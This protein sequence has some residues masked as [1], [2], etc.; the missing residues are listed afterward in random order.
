MPFPRMMRLLQRM[1]CPK[2]DDVAQEVRRE[3][4]KLDLGSRLKPGESVAVTVG[5]RGI[6][7]LPLIIRTMVEMLT[8]QGARP[9]LV[10]AMGSHGGATAEGQ[11]GT[12]AELGIT[13]EFCGAPVKSSME[14]VQ[15]T[16]TERGLPV[17]LDRHAH[18][19]DHVVVVNRVKPH[20]VLSGE[21]ESGLQ[22]MLL[23]GL[24]KQQGADVYHRA[25]HAQSFDAI[26]RSA[27]Q[28]VIEKG[29]ILMGLAIV[30]NPIKQTALIE[31]VKPNEFWEREKKLLIQA[32]EWIP[33]LPF[34]EA[35]LLI[36]DEFGKNISGSGMDTN[37][38]GRK[39]SSHL[40]P[41][42]VSPRITAIYVRDL[43]EQ[44]HGNATGIGRVEFTH[45]RLVDKIDWPSTYMNCLTANAPHAARLPMHFD[46]DRRVL[47]AAMGS[48]LGSDDPTRARV[49]HIKNTMELTEVLVSEA[50]LA[51]VKTREDLSLM[52]QPMEMTFDHNGDFEP[53]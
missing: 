9:F 49:M 37:V 1:P 42:E 14:V 29:R 36:V 5:S 11:A 46:S 2:L 10:P 15:L 34:P 30:E 17:Y 50:Y 39:P 27:G 51:Q 8:A 13:E 22:K 20:T 18:Q 48:V 33:H 44:S 45:Q 26:A 40:L 19:A 52:A 32:K 4:A 43:T 24:G 6:S 41:A 16:T 25:F 38:V 12:L 21:V 23:I 47:E 35:D 31:A 7:N 3:T 53:W 28:A